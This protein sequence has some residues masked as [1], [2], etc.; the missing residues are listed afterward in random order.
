MT[1]REAFEEWVVPYQFTPTERHWAS[2]AWQA[3]TD[4]ALERA[5]VACEV[6]ETDK[7]ALY[8][9]RPP[10]T[11]TEPGRADNYVQGESGGAGACA[12]AIRALKD[13]P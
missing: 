3:A 10:Y 7:W 8:K 13:K 9:G 11:G 5:A 2:V 6:I 12:S 4:A 1:T